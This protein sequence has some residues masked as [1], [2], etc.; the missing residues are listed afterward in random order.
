MQNAVLVADEKFIIGIILLP[1]SV[2]TFS[3]GIDVQNNINPLTP[4][5]FCQKHI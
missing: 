2:S 3:I 1:G 5:A 4:R